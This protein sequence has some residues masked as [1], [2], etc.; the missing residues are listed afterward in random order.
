MD[1]ELIKK[2]FPIK[3]TTL[4]ISICKDLKFAQKYHGTRLQSTVGIIISG[5][6]SIHLLKKVKKNLI[7]QKKCIKDK[8]ILSTFGTGPFRKKNTGSGDSQMKMK[9]M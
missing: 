4:Q 2:Y 7:K 1:V 3:H 5:N 8:P 9:V 6:N